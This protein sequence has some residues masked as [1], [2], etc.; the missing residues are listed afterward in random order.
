MS[1]VGM[2]ILRTRRMTDRTKLAKKKMIGTIYLS[3]SVRRFQ[4]CCFSNYFLLSTMTTFSSVCSRFVMASVW[5][6][7]VYFSFMLEVLKIE[8]E[9]FR[10]SNV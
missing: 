3:L 4:R 2:M 8:L 6:I 10:M 5:P 1:S 9:L 7:L